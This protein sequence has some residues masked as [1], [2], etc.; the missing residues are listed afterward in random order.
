M[1]EVFP[2]TQYREVENNLN[3]W[4]SKWD[5]LLRNNQEVSSDSAKTAL[6]QL[7]EIVSFEMKHS[8]DAAK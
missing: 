4:I 1:W 6:E 3:K 8:K 7:A 5:I 2:I